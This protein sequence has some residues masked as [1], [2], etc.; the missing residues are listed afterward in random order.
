LKP[1]ANVGGTAVGLRPEGDEIDVIVPVYNGALYICDCVSS[2][3]SQTLKPRRIIVVDDG[4]TDGTVDVVSSLHKSDPSVLLH[5]MGGNFGVSA[6]RNAGISLSDAPFIAFVDADDIW[7]PDKLALQMQVFKTAR[8][9]VGFVHSS[10]F[11][12]DEGGTPLAHERGSP[13]LL[14]GNILSRLLREGNVLS[15]SASSVLIKRDVLDAA[16]LFDEQLYY[17]EDLDL[18][19]RLAAISAVGHTP[20][21]VVG[22]RVHGGAAPYKGRDAIALFLQTITAYS[23]WEVRIRAESGLLQKLRKDG[24]SA[25]L[26][27]PQDAVSFYQTLKSSRQD[28]ARNLYGGKFDFWS[29]LLLTATQRA[30]KKLLKLFGRE[31]KTATGPSSPDQ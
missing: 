9:P 21:A 13:P 25:L 6:A 30:C 15:G 2:V 10:Y 22:I 26:R 8:Q 20:E 3:L 1:A 5:R 28:L 19:L 29:G 4:S 12:I 11:L 27:R 7:M 18:W 14:S 24:F 17:A 31:A 23:R 16:G